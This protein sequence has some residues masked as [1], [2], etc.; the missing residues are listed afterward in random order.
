MFYP[1][2]CIVALVL[3]WLLYITLLRLIWSPIA[4]IPGPKLAAITSLYEMYYELIKGGGGQYCFQIQKLHKMY[5]PIVRINPT[6]VHIDDPHYYSHLYTSGRKTDKL[7]STQYRF[8]IPHA[9]FSIPGW[10]QHREQRKALD[11]FFSRKNLSNVIPTMLEVLERACLHLDGVYVDTE[12]PVDLRDFWGAIISDVISAMIFGHPKGYVDCAEFKSPFTEAMNH[13]AALSGWTTYFPGIF[14]LVDRIPSALIERMPSL[15]IVLQ[16]R[17][18]IEKEIRKLELDS[19][20]FQSSK[21]I[22]HSIPGSSKS[23]GRVDYLRDEATSLTAAG[24]ETTTWVCVVG[25]FH[26]LNQPTI[27]DCLVDE[28]NSFQVGNIL[29]VDIR[30]LEKLPYLSAVVHESLRLAFGTIERMPRIDNSNPFHYNEYTIP[31]G[32][33]IGMD[34]YHM[35]MNE[36]VFPNPSTFDPKRWLKSQ[37]ASTPN[38]SPFLT[39]FGHGP[40]SCLG[41][42][43]ARTLIYYGLAMFFSRYSCELF[44][45]TES[46]VQFTNGKIVPRARK[47]SK[48]VRV[49]VSPRV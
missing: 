11:S 35:H 21:T 49:T 41:R 14:A 42:P 37:D 10:E 4:H 29:T 24:A 27:K 30:Q 32:T 13:L 5:G 44:E 12:K 34:S 33:P 3:T 8:N 40:R 45:T 1:I 25:C 28:L 6:E 47:D 38:L 15:R 16:N 2:M 22:F 26:V 48:G 7:P 19:V 36:S 18:D 39:T 17:D 9:T 23:L 31:P 43:L 46:D 20:E